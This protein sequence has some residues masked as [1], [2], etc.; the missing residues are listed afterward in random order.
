MSKLPEPTAGFRW[1]PGWDIWEQVIPA[2]MR[3][4]GVVPMYSEAKV[5]ELLAQAAAARIAAQTENEELK[6]RLAKSGL[7]ARRKYEPVL[8]LALEALVESCGA[9]CNAEY[10]PCHARLAA[11][12]I[13]KVLG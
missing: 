7:D 10:N 12:A 3:E 13:R 5:K 1:N 2:A 8:K 9:R 4:E 6:G 11:T